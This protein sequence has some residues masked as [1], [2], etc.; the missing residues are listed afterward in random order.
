MD[1]IRIITTED[2]SHSLYREDLKETYHSFHGARQES[3]HVFI[4]MGLQYYLDTVRA[5]DV[6]ASDRPLRILEVGFGTGLNA[7]LAALFAEQHQTAIHFETLETI[8]LSADVYKALNYAEGEEEALFAQL[9]DCEWNNPQV[10]T[11][12]FTLLKHEKPLQEFQSSA[13]FDLIF[14]D[15]FAPSKQAELWGKTIMAQAYELT[16][17]KGVLTTYCAK[18]QLKRDLRDVGYEVATLPGAPGKKE[19]VRAQKG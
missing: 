1:N 19:M 18:G 8:P 13:P 2:G 11:Q 10:I 12:F 15:A 7:Y 14:F 9:H 5:A 16:S 4:E 17:A 6:N 3:M